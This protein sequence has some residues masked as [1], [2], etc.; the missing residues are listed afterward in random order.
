MTVI[1]KVLANNV[2]TL[3]AQE[4]ARA[5][6]NIDATKAV[7]A[8]APTVTDIES[9]AGTTLIRDFAKITPVHKSLFLINAYVS[10]E[11]NDASASADLQLGV[12]IPNAIKLGGSDGDMSLSDSA[13]GYGGTSVSVLRK[14]CSFYAVA[15]AGQTLTVK[16]SFQS[17]VSGFRASYSLNYAQLTLE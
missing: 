12:D 15:D 5:R 3:S 7:V 16:G 11:L 14:F 17:T 1:K 9:V 6:A 4:Q 10:I 2:Q 13:F 8:N